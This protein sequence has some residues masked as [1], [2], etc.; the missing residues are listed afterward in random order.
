MRTWGNE[1]CGVTNF[2]IANS[3]RLSTIIWIELVGWTGGLT[4]NYAKITFSCGSF[5]LHTQ[6]LV[7]E[8]RNSPA[9]TDSLYS[10][11]QSASIIK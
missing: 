9:W 2:N 5:S 7:S 10:S 8:Q 11:D 4:F 1:L 3:K 6:A